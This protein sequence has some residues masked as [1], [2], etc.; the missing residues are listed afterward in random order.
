MRECVWVNRFIADFRLPI[1]RSVLQRCMNLLCLRATVGFKTARQVSALGQKPPFK[2]CDFQ[3]LLCCMLTRKPNFYL[4]VFQVLPA[5][6]LTIDKGMEK[7]LI[8]WNFVMTKIKYGI[9]LAYIKY[10]N[11]DLWL[12]CAV[13]YNFIPFCHNKKPMI[14]TPL[15]W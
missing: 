1:L 9:K 8:H 6:P 10:G 12:S 11:K 7:K 14:T 4:N 13:I 2:N 5:C 15:T 3:F